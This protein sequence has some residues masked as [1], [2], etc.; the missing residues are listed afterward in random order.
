MKTNGFP[1]NSESSR[2]APQTTV[3]SSTKPR[4]N[5]WIAW[6]SVLG[7]TVGMLV[8]VVV[9]LNLVAI[10][11]LP[12]RSGFPALRTPNVLTTLFATGSIVGEALMLLVL[13]R[14]LRQKNDSLGRLGLWKSSP[15]IGW[16]VA[17]LVAAL[18][19]VPGVRGL[20]HGAL[21]L[22]YSKILF[23]PSFFH[24]SVALILGC[25]AGF[26][27]EILFRG[28]VMTRL[29][30]AGYGAV[31]QVIASGILFGLAHGL[32]ALSGGVSVGLDIMSHTA[33]LGALYAITYLLSRRSLMPCILAHFLN[34]AIV[35]PWI[36][37]TMFSAR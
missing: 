32:Y 16:S 15:S 36:F 37:L 35:L 12:F 6:L 21:H 34:D 1:E 4:T 3:V 2:P 19:V 31:V 13:W 18:S 28:Y 7:A 9:G 20:H 24:I 11:L 33:L 29:S 26:C 5:K 10:V 23:E 22:A 14:I 8:C 30:D 27:E 17:L 25:G